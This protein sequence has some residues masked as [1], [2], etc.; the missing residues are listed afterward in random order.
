MAPALL[1]R[2]PRRP[3]SGDPQGPHFR[4]HDPFE[5]SA[6]PHLRTVPRWQA[7]PPSHPS[8]RVQEVHPHRP[9]PHRPQGQAPGCHTRG[10][11]VL[12]DLCLRRFAV[13]IAYLKRKSD[14]FAAFK[15]Y[16][17]YHVFGVPLDQVDV[18]GAA[19]DADEPSEDTPDVP[20][21]HDQGGDDSDDPAPP[22]PP[23]PQNAPPPPHQQPPDVPSRSP[24]PPAPPAPAPCAPAP[25]APVA[26]AGPPTTC[27]MP[28]RL[29][30]PQRPGFD[31]NE[32]FAPTPK[33]ASI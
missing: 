23:A 10:L 20:E 24:S 22:A 4:P 18:P 26:P 32:T 12:D 1:A 5:A 29:A 27:R 15:S 30:Q 31:Y 3:L 6:R 16:K 8:L 33:W 19:E 14:A 28:S 11:P 25:S 7:P 2:E 21:L 13:L 9:R 17:A